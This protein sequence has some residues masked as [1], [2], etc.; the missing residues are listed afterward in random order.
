MLVCSRTALEFSAAC[1]C[2]TIEAAK[3]R[4]YYFY[5]CRSAAI[6]CSKIRKEK[7]IRGGAQDEK[8]KAMMTSESVMEWKS[9]GEKAVE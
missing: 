4:I 3:G 2:I 1:W 6:I 9:G 8:E 5:G 7:C